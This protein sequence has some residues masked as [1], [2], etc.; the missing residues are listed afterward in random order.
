LIAP[1]PAETEANEDGEKNEEEN[2]EKENENENENEGEDDDEDESDEEDFN[3]DAEEEED[4]DE[5]RYRAVAAFAPGQ[6][7][8]VDG[9][10]REGHTPLHVAL[11]YGSIQCLRALLEAEA[12][13]YVTL[14]GSPPLH[15]ACAMSG[16]EKHEAF[17]VEAVKALLPHVENECTQDD[18]G[19]TALSVASQHGVL[20][21]VQTLVD[22]FTP[23]N[24]ED[25]VE[26]YVNLRDKTRN[27][28][29]HWAASYGR[30]DVVDFL[31]KSG[32]DPSL[33]NDNRDNA[34]HCAVRGGDV[35]CVE[36]LLKAQPALAKDK[37]VQQQ[38][39][40]DVAAARGR[41]AIAKLFKTTV[42]NVADEDLKRVIIAP[43][44]CFLHH[45]CPP[46]TRLPAD[47]PPPENV[48]RL[49]VLLNETNGTLRG[50]DFKSLNVE[51][52]SEVEPAAWVD[53]LRCHEYAYLKKVQRI[54]D[55]LPDIRMVPR[56]IGTI[57]GDTAVCSQSFNAA[58]SAAGA[59]IEAVER[60]VSGETNKVF[61]AVRPPGH[62]SG[63]LGP[64]GTPGDP[65]GTGS[66]GFCLINNVAVAAAYA[67]C[68]HRKKLR[69]IA[70]VDFDVHHG[71]GTE[72]C[73]QNTA[74][75]A[76]QFTYSLPIGGGTFSMNMYRP[77]LD[78]TDPDEVMFA[79]VH[80]YGRKELAHHFYPGTGPTKSTKGEYELD[81]EEAAT[82]E[83]DGIVEDPM[84]VDAENRVS[85]AQGEQP[86]VLDVGM[87]GT[88][89]KSERGAAWRRVWKGKILPAIN[90][91]EPELIIISAGFDAHAKDDIQGPVNLGVKEQDYEWLTSELMKI[92][93]AHAKGR[94]IS[95][96]EGGYRIQG[97]PVS[98]FGRSVAAHVR[99]LFQPNSEKYDAEKSK[100]EFNEEL[101]Q[102][103]EIREKREA[104]E[105][106]EHRALLERLAEEQRQ[107][108]ETDGGDGTAD[109]DAE[110]ADGTGEKRAAEDAPPTEDAPAPSKRR[111]GAPVDYAA[112]NAKIEAEAAAKRA[113]ADQ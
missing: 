65:I 18:Y 112:L 59:T 16:F 110:P 3:P 61:C 49:N 70:L 71:N 83:E 33:R 109:A 44:T 104:E 5:D 68:V 57:D 84:H 54:C 7:V 108:M 1:P 29:I 87:E 79:S 41:P 94:V 89:K 28:P 48:N 52:V 69:R 42:E 19:R 82:W 101:R 43:D 107:A 106:A 31:L 76:P 10:D 53:V 92:A 14:E 103:R 51:Y 55:K 60:I 27:R 30:G 23:P 22:D 45:S 34:L 64:V 6:K 73:V 97:G 100:A 38:T 62:H 95:V 77:W 13:T 25:T 93:N 21:V 2:E 47:E 40:G 37:N 86:W 81:T 96:L 75:S 111:R 74:P 50:K 36:S 15:I 11:L 67:R 12:K 88:G 72:A 105:E 98:A 66:H 85:T 8:D 46:I 102:R 99:T 20:A 91:F 35:K 26:V 4:E 17:A 56:A 80:G 90:A 113:A 78:E 24:E 39:P 63:P 58:L 9:K 32:A